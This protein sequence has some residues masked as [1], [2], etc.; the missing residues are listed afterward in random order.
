MNA[1]ANVQLIVAGVVLL[2]IVGA[3]VV[4]TWHGSITGEA[5][6]SLLSAVLGGAVVG[7]AVHVGAVQGSKAATLPPR[8]G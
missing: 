7:G 6:V 4:L 5:C 8:S 2:A 1:N 3:V